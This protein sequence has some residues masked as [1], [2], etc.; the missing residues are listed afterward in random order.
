MK[1]IW[2]LFFIYFSWK[3]PT[4]W[5]MASLLLKKSSEWQRIGLKNIKS[6]SSTIK[7]GVYFCLLYGF[8]GK[9]KVA[10]TCYSIYLPPGRDSMS[11]CV[12]NLFLNS[13]INASY[14]FIWKNIMF[15]LYSWNLVE[16]LSL[17]STDFS[18]QFLF[19]HWIMLSK[20]FS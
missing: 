19:S 3:K 8:V 17:L 7:C 11:A 14:L 6:L 12:S 15:N 16:L 20:L 10:D 5:N 13:L 9:F 2:H 18:V 4:C 1:L